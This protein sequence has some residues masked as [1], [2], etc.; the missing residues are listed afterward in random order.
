MKQ[1]GF[2][3]KLSAIFSEMFTQFHWVMGS[4]KH[5]LVVTKKKKHLLVEHTNP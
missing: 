3:R 4:V 5:L 1:S 2:E